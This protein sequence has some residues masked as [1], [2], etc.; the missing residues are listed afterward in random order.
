MQTGT[1]DD[2]M[3]ANNSESAAKIFSLVVMAEMSA[4][5]PSKIQ[6]FSTGSGQQSSRHRD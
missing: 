1:L 2:I 5:Q 3:S 6:R 4:D